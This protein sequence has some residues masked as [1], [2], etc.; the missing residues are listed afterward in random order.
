MASYSQEEEAGPRG[1]RPQD[2]WELCEQKG[3]ASEARTGAV[4]ADG[5]SCHHGGAGVQLHGPA[6]RPMGT[7]LAQA[8]LRPVHPAALSLSLESPVHRGP[9]RTDWSPEAMLTVG[10]SLCNC[11][12]KDLI[13]VSWAQRE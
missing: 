10:F 4:R 12:F 9:R 2:T 1:H 3:K 6:D 7:A 8:A 5:D 11:L 13:G